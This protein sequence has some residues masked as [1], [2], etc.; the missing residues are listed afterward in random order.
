MKLGIPPYKA[1]NKKYSLIGF[2]FAQYL[3]ITLKRAINLR[4]AIAQ[5]D[6]APAF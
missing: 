3:H 6:R 4:F 2:L 1:L 5:L